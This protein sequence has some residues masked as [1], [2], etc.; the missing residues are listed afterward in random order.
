MNT[1]DDYYDGDMSDREYRAR[2]RRDQERDEYYANIRK[3]ETKRR[4]EDRSPYR[5]SSD[6]DGVY[7][8]Y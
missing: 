6:D 7:S 4:S 1:E 8:S 3:N 5:F 2:V